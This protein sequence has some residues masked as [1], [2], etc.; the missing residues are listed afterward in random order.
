MPSLTEGEEQDAAAFQ[1]MRRKA[2]WIPPCHSIGEQD[3]VYELIEKAQ[4]F[5][6]DAAIRRGLELRGCCEERDA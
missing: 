3:L 1:E 5:A 4:R 2:L 6:W